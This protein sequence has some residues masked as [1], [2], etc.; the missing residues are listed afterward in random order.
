MNC[1]GSEERIALPIGN[2]ILCTETSKAKALIKPK[3]PQCNQSTIDFI[4]GLCSVAFKEFLQLCL[5]T[6]TSTTIISN[7]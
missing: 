4:P 7:T 1:S 2:G 6:T 5:L 3:S